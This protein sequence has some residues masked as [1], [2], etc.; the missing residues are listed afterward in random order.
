[1]S[2][3]NFNGILFS[4]LDSVKQGQRPSIAK[5]RSPTFSCPVVRL[6]IKLLATLCHFLLQILFVP[7][8]SIIGDSPL[9]QIKVTSSV[10]INRLGKSGE[11]VLFDTSL[12]QT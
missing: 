9:T 6:I 5:P 3:L 12:V 8:Y 4:I 7:L 1:M 11:L 10:A 2:Y